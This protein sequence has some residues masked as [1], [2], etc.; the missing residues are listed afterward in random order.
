[1]PL[2]QLFTAAEAVQ[3]LSEHHGWQVLLSLIDGEVANIDK[4][5]DADRVLDSKAEYARLLGRRGGLRAVPGLAQ[6]LIE[7]AESELEA[8]RRKHEGAGETAPERAVV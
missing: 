1:M 5:L 4:A 3:S 6:A 7:K 2:D 8:Q